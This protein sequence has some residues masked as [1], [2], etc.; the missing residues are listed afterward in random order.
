VYLPELQRLGYVGV[1]NFPTVGLIDGMFRQSLEETGMGFGHERAMIASAHDLGMLT[2][3]YVFKPE[4]AAQMAAAG[5]DLIVA[6]MGVTVKGLVGAQTSMSLEQAAERCQA[7][8]EA[9]AATSPHALV[10]CH[11]GPIA[12]PD[13]ARYIFEHTRGVVGFFGASSMER[14]PT[15]RAMTERISEF[16]GLS[17]ATG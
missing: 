7:I 16:T 14:L 11:G 3:P 10:L 9:A 1:Q 15:E 17:V 6:H 8:Q 12:E 4:E 5:A 13:D 2:A